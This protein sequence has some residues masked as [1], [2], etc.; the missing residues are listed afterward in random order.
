MTTG[1]INGDLAARAFADTERMPWTP[2][3]SGTVWRKRVH[4]VG[5]P[6][7]GQVT[8]VV[9]Y[10][11]DSTFPAHPHPD[12]EEILVLDGVFSDQEGD[13]PAGTYLLNP[14]GFRHAPFSKRGCLLFVKL[15]QSPGRERKHVAIDTNR[16]GW[17]E[18]ETAGVACKLLYEQAGFSD[19]VRLER[20]APRTELGVQSYPH[21]V[22]F[23]VLEGG[24]GDEN[25]AYSRGCW[26]R[27]PAGTM[28]RPRSPAGCILYVKRGGLPYLRSAS[29]SA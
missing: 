28:H 14:E 17:Q 7:S 1:A 12:G 25:G 4:L 20:W 18:A 3:P 24:F 27:L 19:V 16:L 22:E 29:E 13:W 21:G 11:P 9:R 2:S 6:E 15:R 5:P 10:E 23:F 8:S 26:L